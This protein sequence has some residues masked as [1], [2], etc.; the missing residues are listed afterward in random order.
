MTSSRLPPPEEE[1]EAEAASA[2]VTA[3]S[4]ASEAELT[5]KQAVSGDG[6]SLTSRRA[7]S[8]VDWCSW[9]TPLHRDSEARAEETPWLPWPRMTSWKK[10]FFLKKR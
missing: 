2:M 9:P 10:V 7:S 4:F 6:S 3:R 5:K 8:T 1:L